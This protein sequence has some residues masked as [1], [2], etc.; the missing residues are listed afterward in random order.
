[1]SVDYDSILT[2]KPVTPLSEHPFV[3]DGERLAD[4]DVAGILRADVQSSNSWAVLAMLVMLGILLSLLVKNYDFLKYKFKDF[5]ASERRFSNAAMMPDASELPLTLLLIVVSCGC[6]G[7]ILHDLFAEMPLLNRWLS[8]PYQLYLLIFALVLLLV[9][10]KAFLYRVVNW[11]F[12]PRAKNQKWMASYFFLTAMT[13][14]VVFVIAALYVFVN[15]SYME[16]AICLLILLFL[17][18]FLLFYKLNANFQAKKYGQVL[19][20]LYFCAVE[21]VPLLAIWHFFEQNSTI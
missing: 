9:L 5:M 21:I 2:Q 18:E 14:F 7:F 10:A 6:F 19:I 3:V 17:Y 12:F 15:I 4:W 1:M 16:V 11:V 8:E 20:F 13:S